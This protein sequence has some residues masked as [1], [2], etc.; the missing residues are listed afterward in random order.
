MIMSS[1]N[2]NCAIVRVANY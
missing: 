1:R 2:I